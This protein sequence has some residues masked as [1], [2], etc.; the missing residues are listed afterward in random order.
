MARRV[1]FGLFLAVLGG[2]LMGG[3]LPLGDSGGSTTVTGSGSGTTTSGDDLEVEFPGCEPVVQADLWRAQILMLVNQE[4]TARGLGTVVRNDTLEDQATRYACEMI[5]Y[6]FFDHVN[7]VTG[8]TLADRAADFG[9]SY[10]V[11]GENLA[12]GQT[13]PEQ[14]MADW[15]ASPGHRDN[16]LDERFTE[17]GVGIRTGG[18]YGTYWVQEFGLPY[19]D[20]R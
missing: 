5:H 19:S 12:A 6:D 16:I 18:D 15:L 1:L 17:L 2:S 3:C 11:I 9:Y 14:V 10:L 4:R 8:S 20:S 7:P 13:S